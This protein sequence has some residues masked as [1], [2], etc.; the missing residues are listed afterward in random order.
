MQDYYHWRLK[1]V[2]FT[3]FKRMFTKYL[4]EAITF[5][6]DNFTENGHSR[7]KLEKIAQEYQNNITKSIQKTIKNRNKNLAF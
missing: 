3:K 2:P 7:T 4:D 6:I 5:S 1:R